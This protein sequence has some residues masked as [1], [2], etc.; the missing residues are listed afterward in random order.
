[1]L[2]LGESPDINF[3]VEAL[4][5]EGQEMLDDIRDNCVYRILWF[6]IKFYK[7]IIL[8]IFSI[9][10]SCSTFISC[11]LNLIRYYNCK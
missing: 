11:S 5:P 9:L 4:T 2:V 3:A 7:K 1:M 10:V 8:F 6:Y